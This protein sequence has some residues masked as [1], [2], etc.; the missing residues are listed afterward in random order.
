MEGVTTGK[1]DLTVLGLADK[2]RVWLNGENLRKLH[3]DPRGKGLLIRANSIDLN[4]PAGE[5]L[6]T[7]EIPKFLGFKGSAANVQPFTPAAAGEP[8]PT[9]AKNR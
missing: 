6:L 5:K 1:G 8:D 9:V 2:A 4:S 3:M 7:Q